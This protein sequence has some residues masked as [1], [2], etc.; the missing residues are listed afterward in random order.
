MKALV[1]LEHRG[2]DITR[3][4]LSVLSKAAALQPD[5]GV[6]AVLAG[7]AP[8]APLAEVAGRYGAATVHIAEGDGLE[9]PLPQPRVGILGDVVGAHGYDTVMFSTSVL[10][11]DVAA[12]LAARLGA[13]LNW[14]LVDLLEE[15]GALVG[16]RTALQESVLVDV[17]WRSG[18]RLALFRPGVFEPQAV[19]GPPRVE[20]A[21]VEPAEPRARVVSQEGRDDEGPS[22]ED[23]EVIVAGGIG[24]GGAEQFA[25]AEELASLLGGAVAA[26]RAVVYKGWYP[27][28]AQVG[29][30][31]KTVAPKL[32]VA[33]G[34]S[35]AVQHKVGMRNSKVIVS[36]NKNP[37][38]PIFEV[39]D[40]AVIGDV[41]VIVP[42]L[43]ELLRARRG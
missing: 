18:L 9:P 2:E 6:G 31:G 41:H 28:S 20:Q 29:Q 22:I 21:T 30:T 38:A 13:G 14:D 1:F 24:L 17:G 40:L 32:Y 3:G 43:I 15:G 7:R 34:I 16:R 25:M 23:A 35:G 5:G 12:G 27:R 10:A 11:S 4:S 33:L 42:Q 26:T 37:G 8:L 36:I 19:G 39:S